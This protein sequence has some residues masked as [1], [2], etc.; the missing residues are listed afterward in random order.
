MLLLRLKCLHTRKTLHIIHF[1]TSPS[2]KS[3]ISDIAPGNQHDFN[4]AS[5]PK[6]CDLCYDTLDHDLQNI[7]PEVYQCGHTFCL[8]C[9][10]TYLTKRTGDRIQCPLCQDMIMTENV[11]DI[12]NDHVDDFEMSQE[13]S[14][15]HKCCVH[16]EKPVTFT[17]MDC[18]V[19]VCNTCVIR[20][21]HRDHSLAEVVVTEEDTIAATVSRLTDSLRSLDRAATD[22][23]DQLD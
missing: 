8:Q 18:A 7:L 15:Q 22:T 2:P 16:P 1:A 11:D 12:P 17:C 9:V 3:N 10:D 5:V 19:S 14:S 21:K 4:M 13:C 23:A 20:G 6:P